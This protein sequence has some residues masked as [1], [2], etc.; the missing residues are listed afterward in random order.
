M[1]VFAMVLS[2]LSIDFAQADNKEINCSSTR[3]FITALQFFRENSS[4]SIH[5]NDAKKV[6]HQV[7]HG[8][9]GAAQRF[10]SV[11][12]LL[13]KAGFSAKDS[14]QT[15]LE[16][17]Y[18]TSTEAETFI[19]VFMKAYLSEYLDLDL[20]SAIKLAKSMSSSFQGD[21]LGV[22]EDFEKIIRFCTSAKDL[23]WPR[24]KCAEMAVKITKLGQNYSG[25]IGEAFIRTF[26]FSRSKSGIALATFDALNIAEE[27]VSY[28]PGS[29]ENFIQAYQYAISKGGLKLSQNEA[30]VFAKDMA[31]STI[32]KNTA[33]K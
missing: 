16:F 6:A 17:V 21:A 25:G 20:Y 3:E 28:G 15:G 31:Q 8:C 9:T 29:A 19:V 4:L 24:P 11:T 2:F 27:V 7:A 14:I 13:L 22:R 10:I 12:Q 26:D 5:D 23:N 30:L 1:I 33:K 18:K 32:L